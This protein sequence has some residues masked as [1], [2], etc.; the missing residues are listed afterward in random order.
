MELQQFKEVSQLFMDYDG[1]VQ[2]NPFAKVHWGTVQE[3]HLN[4]KLFV[5]NDK[6]YGIIGSEAKTSRE[7]KDFS[8]QVVGQIKAVSYTHLTL[9]TILLV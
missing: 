1:E 5:D 8:N 7:V 3:N 9:P 2:I 4:G 6:N